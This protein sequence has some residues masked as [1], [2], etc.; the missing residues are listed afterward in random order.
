[1]RRLAGGSLE[2]LDCVLSNGKIFTE[3]RDC[4]GCFRLVRTILE[5][6]EFHLPLVSKIKLQFSPGLKEIVA[7]MMIYNY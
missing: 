7:G 6:C 5:L 1:M 3:I 4:S 2:S